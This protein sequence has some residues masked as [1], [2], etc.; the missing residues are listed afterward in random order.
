MFLQ[1][2]RAEKIN[3]EMNFK[4]EGSAGGKK[5]SEHFSYVFAAVSREGKINRKT[6]PQRDY[7]ICPRGAWAIDISFV[8]V[9]FMLL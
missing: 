1:L 9:D 5:V 8:G 7:A 3:S 6:F 2:A 4:T